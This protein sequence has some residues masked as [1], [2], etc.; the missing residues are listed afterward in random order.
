[1]EESSRPSSLSLSLSLS[2]VGLS[3]RVGSTRG[4]CLRLRH[5]QSVSQS[6]NGIGRNLAILGIG[7]GGG[8]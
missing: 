1:M 3:G 6:R 7:N 4:A 2:F 8:K 5:G